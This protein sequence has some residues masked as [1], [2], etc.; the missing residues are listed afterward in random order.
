VS[1]AAAIPKSESGMVDTS[2]RCPI[3]ESSQFLVYNGRVNAQCSKCFAQERTRLLWMILEKK[4]LFKRGLRVMHIAPERAIAK[5]YFELSA[6]R[7]FA[8][9]IDP[10]RYSGRYATVRPIDLCCDLV[11]LPSRSFDLIIH[12]HVL[13]HVRCDPE[14]ILHELERILAPGGDHFLCVPISGTETREDLSDDLTPA[15]RTEMFLQA[16]HYRVFGTRSLKE[17]LDRVWGV[18]EKHHVEPL[19]LFGV[20][21]LEAAAIPR[22]S[23][24]GI[25]GVS[26]FHHVRPRSRRVSMKG[27]PSPRADESADLTVGTGTDNTSAIFRRGGRNLILHIGMPNAGAKSLQQW[28]TQNRSAALEAGLDYWSIAPNHSDA[29]LSVFGDARRTA[30]RRIEAEQ[31]P[32]RVQLDPETARDSLDQFFSGLNGSIGFISADQLWTFPSAM[33]KSLA[34]YLHDRGVQ[35]LVLCSVSPA[36]E[37]ITHTALRQCRSSLAIGEFGPGIDVKFAIRYSR[38][39]AWIENFGRDHVITLPYDGNTVQLTRNLLESLG[40]Q[41]EAANDFDRPANPVMSLLAAKALLAFHQAQKSD[42]SAT[43]WSPR[44]RSVLSG[45]KGSDF[46]LPEGLLRNMS[47]QLERDARYLTEQFSMNRDWLLSDGIGMDDA[48]FFQW[49]WDEVASLLAAVNKA[50]LQTDAV[51][52]ESVD[53]GA[54]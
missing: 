33:V 46:H 48:L 29:M 13:E 25:S 12:T 8:C 41:L 39:R 38:L 27:S 17:M 31:K 21:E 30:K 6:D 4:G 43:R 47:A 20:D 35:P 50:L 28:F 14:S 10:S 36:A 7:Y 16:D 26:I 53:S 3:C 40:I 11:K 19:E 52:G 18:R 2:L 54:D 9:D 34:A 49:G 44:L 45:L 23:W 42:E 1:D 32:G 37:Y 22:K 15:Q 51:S 24:T 5:R